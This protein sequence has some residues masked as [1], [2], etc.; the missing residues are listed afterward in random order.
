LVLLITFLLIQNLLCRGKEKNITKEEKPNRFFG[1]ATSFNELGLLGYTLNG[2]YL[3]EGKENQ[4]QQFPQVQLVLCHFK[5][6]LG[7]SEGKAD[8][9]GNV[10]FFFA[11]GDVVFFR[12]VD[13]FGNV[14]RQ[15][16]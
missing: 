1:P 11:T 9:Y 12:A 6:P 4:Q 10:R 8:F 13:D 2:F 15:E 16:I 5:R 14:A 7:T 3:V